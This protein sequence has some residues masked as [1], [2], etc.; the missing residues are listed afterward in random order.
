MLVLLVL[1]TQVDLRSFITVNGVLS[2]TN[3]GHFMTQS[4]YVRAWVMH[5]VNSFI[6]QDSLI[7]GLVRYTCMCYNIF[8][9]MKTVHVYIPSNDWK[10]C[11]KSNSW[12]E[13]LML[14]TEVIWE[15]FCCNRICNDI[16]NIIYIYVL[17]DGNNGLL[18]LHICI[19]VLMVIIRVGTKYSSVL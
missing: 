19:H 10:L 6:P 11:L 16:S 5:R 7:L 4:W 1:S 2:V 14:Y 15:K 18:I 9:G 3:L 17:Y 12:Y 8:D 13:W